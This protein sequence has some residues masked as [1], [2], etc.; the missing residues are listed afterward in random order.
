MGYV[1][2][3][4]EELA[5]KFKNRCVSQQNSIDLAWNQL[6]QPE[7]EDLRGAICADESEL[8]RFLQI[9]VKSV[10]ATDYSDEELVERRKVR[11]EK[12]FGDS[13][14]D[15]DLKATIAMVLLLQVSFFIRFC[16][17]FQFILI[18]ERLLLLRPGLGFLSLPSTLAGKYLFRWLCGEDPYPDRSRVYAGIQKM[19]GKKI[20]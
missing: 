14:G 13:S 2:E 20:L 5:S 9:L 10:L 11:W 15:R 18:R 6:M 1:E 19:V 17:F 16:A 7:F 12:A 4:G 8:K 3:N